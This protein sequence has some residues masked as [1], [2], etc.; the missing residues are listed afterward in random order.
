[1]I[2]LERK[3]ILIA[4]GDHK[5]LD[6]LSSKLSARGFEVFP[7]KDGSKALETTLFKSPDLLIIDTDLD[8]LP[9]EKLTQ[10]VRSNPK[11]KG[12]PIIYLSREEKSLPSFS[13]ETDEFVMKPFNM[14][15]FIL[16][17]SKIFHHERKESVFVSGDTE[18]SGKL[19][20]MSLPDL[21]QMFTFN[22]Q[23]GALHI[24]STRVSGSIYMLN[25]E[26]ISALSGTITG[27]KAFYRMITLQEGEFQFIP[28]NFEMDKTIH[29]NS[30]NIILEGLRRYDEISTLRE[31][32]PNPE[33]SIELL[34]PSHEMPATSSPVVK[35]LVMLAEFYSKVEDIVNESKYTDYDVYKALLSLME[36]KFIRLGKFEKKC[37]KPEFL[38]REEIITL[39][40]RF[41]ATHKK[42]DSLIVA[43]ILFF[44]PEDFRLHNIISAFNQFSEFE[45]D[46]YFLSAKNRENEPL[47]GMFGYL[48]VGE[49]AR[50]ALMSFRLRREHSPLWYAISRSTAGVI[51]ILQDE[52]TSSLEDLLAVSEFAKNIGCGTILG[53]KSKSFSNFGLGDNTLSLYKKRA[54]KMGCSIKIKEMEVL[55]SQEIQ[56]SVQEVLRKYMARIEGTH[57]RPSHPFHIQ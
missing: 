57:D 37:V 39:R 45:V 31:S 32:F 54:E 53:V 10:I 24:A 14:S 4:D 15:E 46:R 33:D 3:K 1:M 36:R 27:E 43:K 47:M 56:S 6:G 12:V 35:E 20:Q 2:G 21:L 16:R 23:S 42:K 25:G 26:I 52:M 13:K 30:Q 18:I 19:S 17:V 28:G 7:V 44:I 29:K 55:S 40:S 22:K 11:T 34:R 41:D 48:N 38:D 51:V 49:Q 8:L 50:L 5:I 9:T